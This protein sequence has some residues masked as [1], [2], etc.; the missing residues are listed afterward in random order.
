MDAQSVVDSVACL[1][2][3]PEER[4]LALVRVTDGRCAPRSVV[5]ERQ[6]SVAVVTGGVVLAAAGQTTT[7]G[8]T[9]IAIAAAAVSASSSPCVLNALTLARV[10]VALASVNHS[11]VHVNYRFSSLACRK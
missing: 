5:V 3:E 9:I 11:H 1:R 4:T 10:S 7:A 2:T 8:T 6:T